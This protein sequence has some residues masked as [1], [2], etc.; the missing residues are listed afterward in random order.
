MCVCMR[1]YVYGPRSDAQCVVLTSLPPDLRSNAT[2][3]MQVC[4][5]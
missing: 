1:I 2:P 4:A 3:E 5:P